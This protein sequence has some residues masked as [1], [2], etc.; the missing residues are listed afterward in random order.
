M[1]GGWWVLN[2]CWYLLWSQDSLDYN[3]C[4]GFCPISV[5]F[6]YILLWCFFDLGIKSLTMVHENLPCVIG[7]FLSL[8]TQH[9]PLP[10]V[11]CSCHTGRS[12]LATPSLS[13]CQGL[14]A[15]SILCLDTLSPFPWMAGPWTFL[16][17]LECDLVRE[18]IPNFLL[19]SWFSLLASTECPVSPT[20]TL[21]TV[22]DY[23]FISVLA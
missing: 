17:Q 19:N 16:P 7:S 14:H 18:A 9:I 22:C 2:K 1:P 15:C 11:H 5:Q 21:V 6:L 3:H 12:S 8:W 23:F 20:M 13:P 10:I 4:P